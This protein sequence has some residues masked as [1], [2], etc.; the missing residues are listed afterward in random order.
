[1]SIS[2]IIHVSDPP[3]ESEGFVEEG[4]GEECPIGHQLPSKTGFFLA[5]NARYALSK[6]SA[7]MVRACISAS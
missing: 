6:S 3:R 2:R 5:A 7:R 4:P 1:M